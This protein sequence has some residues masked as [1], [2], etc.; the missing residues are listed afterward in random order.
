MILR[1]ATEASSRSA[2][3]RLS[4]ARKSRAGQYLR[5]LLTDKVRAFIVQ[6]HGGRLLLRIRPIV[7]A[8][9]V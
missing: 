7:G 1:G 3:L 6:I 9:R 2:S 5:P 8:A 4:V